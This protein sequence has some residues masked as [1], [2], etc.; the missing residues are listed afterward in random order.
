M[1]KFLDTGAL[2]DHIYNVFAGVGQY[3][4]D[5]RAGDY[6][7]TVSASK[8]LGGG[9]LLELSHEKLRLSDLVVRRFRVGLLAPQT[10]R[11][12]G[13]RCRRRC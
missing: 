4:P 6:R 1:K 10:I 3:L 9:A 13:F 8:D 2:G 5:W 7:V 12:T 11:R